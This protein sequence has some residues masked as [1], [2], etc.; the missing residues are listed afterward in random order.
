[1]DSLIFG[2]GEGVISLETNALRQQLARGKGKLLDFFTV[3]G[4][5]S[6]DKGWETQA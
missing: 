5:K 3:R 6:E 1:M 4:G 2:S